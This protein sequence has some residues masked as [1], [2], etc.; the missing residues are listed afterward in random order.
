MNDKALILK[1]IKTQKQLTLDNLPNAPIKEKNETNNHSQEKQ[2]T[3]TEISTETREDE[4]ALKVGFKL[5]P[6]KAAFSKVKSNLSFNNQEIRS[7]LIGIPQGPLTRDD[8]ELTPILDMKGI[9]A[10]LHSV[11]VEMYEP[12]S[13]GEKLSLTSKEVTVEYI[14]KTRE[15]RLIKIPI[16]K[17][18]GAKDLVV[19]SDSD[20]NIYREIEETVKKESVAKRDEW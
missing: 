12:W 5:L 15:S 9:A 4:L 6:S 17:S 20:R 7:V 16:V 2:I 18:F 13:S 8:F 1:K 10:G 3:I 14:P 11:K 19:I